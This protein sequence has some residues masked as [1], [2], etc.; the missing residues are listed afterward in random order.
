MA[1]RPNKSFFMPMFCRVS[2]N[3]TVK[4]AK[5]SESSVA[6]PSS[7]KLSC[8]G[9]IKKRS[10]ATATTTTNNN[11]FLADS[12][13]T[14]SSVHSNLSYTKLHRFFSGK[15]LISPAIDTASFSNCSRKCVTNRSNS[16]NGRGRIPSSTKKYYKSSSDD[17]VLM[18]VVV[19][20]E[21]DP[22]LPVV[23]CARRDQ[24]ANVNLWKRRGIEMKTLQIQPIQL[25]LDHN[26]NNNNVNRNS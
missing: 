19:A 20:E 6:D 1:S 26:T 11:R 15:N 2:I 17:P 22:P 8:I 21:L 4:P 16:C 5:L 25:S 9:Q 18:R 24:E 12:T 13:N 10:T 14:R 3:D 23:K 7:P